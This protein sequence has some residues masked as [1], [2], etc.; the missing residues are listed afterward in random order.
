MLTGCSLRAMRQRLRALARRIAS[1]DVPITAV[2]LLVGGTAT[3]CVAAVSSVRSRGSSASDASEQIKLPSEMSVGER[4]LV[5]LRGRG[6]GN[7]AREDPAPQLAAAT[8]ARVARQQSMSIS[9][10]RAVGSVLFGGMGNGGLV[11]SGSADVVE[12]RADVLEGAVDAALSAEVAADPAEEEGGMAA[13]NGA[14]Q[15]RVHFSD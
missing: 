9:S 10:D 11:F 6:P 3:L 12:Q 5:R 4:L 1:G 7:T 13:S 15:V 14:Q 2:P 8:A